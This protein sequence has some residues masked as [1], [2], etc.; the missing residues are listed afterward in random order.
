MIAHSILAFLGPLGTALFLLGGTPGCYVGTH[1]SPASVP[2]SV[3]KIYHIVPDHNLACNTKN[4]VFGRMYFERVL[5]CL[6][7]SSMDIRRDV[8]KRYLAY[9]L[10]TILMNY[11]CEGWTTTQ[12][13][14]M[15]EIVA[16]L[17]DLPKRNKKGS[18]EL[19]FEVDSYGWKAFCEVWLTSLME[20]RPHC[21]KMLGAQKIMEK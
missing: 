5:P 3:N 17:A 10:P 2:I 18:L 9:H 20:A 14:W 19:H 1:I 7:L 4:P 15:I 21:I 12:Q 6:E 11:P 16:Y 13:A 8:L